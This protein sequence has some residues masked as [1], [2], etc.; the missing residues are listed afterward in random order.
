MKKSY[1]RYFTL[2]SAFCL[3][4]TLTTAQTFVNGAAGGANDGSSWTNAYTDLG[5]ALANTTAGEIWVAGGTYHP[6]ADTSSTFLISNG[7]TLLGGFAGTETMVSE[8]DFTANATVLSGDVNEDDIPDDFDTNKSDNVRHI[9]T[10]DSLLPSMVTIDGF[11]VTK[12]FGNIAAGDDGAGI[13][14]YSPVT[15]NNCTFTQNAASGGSSVMLSPAAGDGANGSVFENCTFSNNLAVDNAAGIFVVS[16]DNIT[17]N[18]C[19]FNNNTTNR[20]T[21]YPIFSTNITLSNSTFDNNLNN[22][23]AGACMWNWNSVG[24]NI[25]NCQFTNNTANRA[26]VMLA[27]GGDIADMNPTDM[28][29]TDCLFQGNT[30]IEDVAAIWSQGANFTLNNCQFIDNTAPFAGSHMYLSGGN[31]AGN[32]NDCTFSGGQSGRSAHLEV[33]SNNTVLNFTN[34]TFENGVSGGIA[35]SMLLSDS[36]VVNFTGCDFNENSATTNAGVMWVQNGTQV[37]LED[38]DMDGNTGVNG[39]T[40]VVLANDNTPTLVTMNNSA[41]T[42]NGDDMTEF[43]GAILVLSGDMTINNSEFSGNKGDNGGAMF[44]QGE[45]ST[46][47]ITNSEFESNSTDNNG[48]ALQLNETNTYIV[49]NCLFEGNASGT[50]GALGSTQFS[51]VGGTIDLTV[52][53]CVFE[54]NV[55]ETQGGAVNIFD[56]TNALFANNQF[57]NNINLYQGMAGS[58]GAGGALSFNAG[59][60]AEVNIMFIHN[61]VVKNESLLGLGAV[62]SFTGTMSSDLTLTM[63]NNILDNPDSDNYVIEDGTPTLATLGGNL[64]SDDSAASDLTDATDQHE[65]D[66]MKYINSNLDNYGVETDSPAKGAG[67]ASTVTEDIVG[68]PRDATNPTSGAYEFNPDVVSVKET[69][70]PNAGNLKVLPNPV[71]EILTFELTN[72]WKGDME[73]RIYNVQGQLIKNF[74]VNKGEEVLLQSTNVSEFATG[75]YDIVISDSNQAIVTKFVKL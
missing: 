64:S 70:V 44:A 4:S 45:T 69:I 29:I 23:G 67:T 34:T 59:D 22:T 54:S 35:G 68:F 46:V 42:D 48:G 26:S 1:L 58:G 11:V 56:V 57:S 36:A 55:A 8:R 2:L 21:F 17:V 19:T 50:G 20:G 37:T 40:V 51:D 41:M 5:N 33:F 24:F 27:D 72:E 53:N 3:I 75:L 7:I 32:I 25:T 71:S 61:T 15:V 18:N 12:G 9:V 62:T 31:M 28:V 6:G 16:Q 52:T 60:T 43:G 73:V 74:K 14:V 49:D 30:V 38:T 65:V 39:S 47:S 10:V 66:D 13:F 63:Q